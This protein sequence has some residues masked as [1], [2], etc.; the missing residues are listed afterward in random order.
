M[1][2][3]D[4]LYALLYCVVRVLYAVLYCYC[5]VQYGCCTLYFTVTV[6][7]STGAVH[8]T[9][10]CC[11]ELHCTGTVRLLRYSA[12]CCVVLYCTYCAI[13]CC[14]CRLQTEI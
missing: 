8:C 14:S 13:L 4:M 10:F 7:I 2:A 5:T 11:A 12:L 6:L 1:A 3:T 9:V